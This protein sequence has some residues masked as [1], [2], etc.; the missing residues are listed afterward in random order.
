MHA[1]EYIGHHFLIYCILFLISLLV[2]YLIRE[3]G[4]INHL[5][6]LFFEKT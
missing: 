4:I 1:A 5:V 3:T 2:Q 6:F